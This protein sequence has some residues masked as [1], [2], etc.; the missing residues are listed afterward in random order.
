MISLMVEMRINYDTVVKANTA[1]LGILNILKTSP[2][3]LPDTVEGIRDAA[4]AKSKEF[5]QG[6]ELGPGFF[7]LDSEARARFLNRC[8]FKRDVAKELEPKDVLNLARAETNP[9]AKEQLEKAY[10][11]MMALINYGDPVPANRK[12]RLERIEDNNYGFVIRAFEGGEKEGLHLFGTV[13]RMIE[14]EEFRA[15]LKQGTL[16]PDMTLD[17]HGKEFVDIMA[18]GIIRFCW[19]NKIPIPKIP[20]EFEEGVVKIGR[21]SGSDGGVAFSDS[22][23]SLELL[24]WLDI[25]D[26]YKFRDDLFSSRDLPL[27][28]DEKVSLAKMI[29]SNSFQLS[30]QERAYWIRQWGGDK[31]ESLAKT[32]EN[33]DCQRRLVFQAMQRLISEGFKTE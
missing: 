24:T 3:G 12:T 28:I 6:Q 13:K 18:R 9:L 20:K 26:S 4:I 22:K 5:K 27:E 21:E 29:G 30:M 10:Y 19:E 8:G 17:N 31:A 33:H 32:F 15:K 25:P 2:S 7:L 1:A 23:T 16:A 11:L 14:H